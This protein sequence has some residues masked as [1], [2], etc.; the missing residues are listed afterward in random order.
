V[1]LLL[2]TTPWVSRVALTYH[3]TILKT[4]VS[5]LLLGITVSLAALGHRLRPSRVVRLRRPAV[6]VGTATLLLLSA[7]VLSRKPSTARA[8][9]DTTSAQLSK[10]NVILI[11]MDTVR[12]DHLSVYGYQRDTTPHLRDFAREATVYTRAIATSDQ[13]LTTHASMFTGLYPGWHDAYLAP[14]DYPRGRPLSPHYVTLAEA[15]CSKGYWTAGV[16]ANYAY[17]QPSL[18][19]ARGFAK[20][21]FASPATISSN[22]E[23]FYLREGARR[24]LSLAVDTAG[25]DAA[26]LRAADIN[27][28]AIA[29]LNQSTHD[30]LFF[31]FLN[32][33]DAHLPYVPR[34]PFN[35]LFPGRDPHV[36]PRSEAG[37]AFTVITGHHHINEAENR[38]F[39]SQYDGAIAYMDSEIGNLLAGLR[40]S[41]LYENT[42]IIITADHGE[43]FGERDLMTHELGFVYQN[44]VR[45]P[46]LVKYPGQHEA[47]Q[48][49]TLTS[50]VDLMPTVLDV[51]EISL[52]P[53]VQG[54]TLRLPRT[55]GS[56]KAYSEAMAM[57]I[58]FLSPENRRFRG[59]RRAI[60]AGH[61]KLITWTEGPSELYDLETDPNETRNQYRRADPRAVALG[62][63]LTAWAAAAPPQLAQ[64]HKLD[65]NSV[66][67]LK[68]LGYAQ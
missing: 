43:A 35:N 62:D 49:D 40:Q 37:L 47:R 38:H 64:P 34:P 14:P 26:T 68:S 46:L 66:E 16:V 20:Y 63:Q 61:W 5:L 28:R 67:R 12:A 27:R 53:C 48:V 32:Y 44:Q 8:N 10:P 11:T 59:V 6:V 22:H 52:P 19:L 15:L 4:A 17:L 55:D 7:V 56:D 39:V 1:S 57:P 31:L 3:S 33:M 60:L 24:L 21:E 51:A 54:H 23:R 58:P 41:G 50:Q 18:G 30:R 9:Q 13:T 36:E 2:L 45:I 65:K 29:L 42:L 25:F